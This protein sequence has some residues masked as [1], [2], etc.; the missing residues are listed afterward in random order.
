MPEETRIE[1]LILNN[2]FH[3]EDFSRKVIPYLKEEYF[4]Q[5]HEKLIFKHTTAFI[6]KYNKLPTEAAIA[7][8]VQG[9]TTM[10]EETYQEVVDALADVKEPRKVDIDWLVDQTES[11]CQEKA[12]F[13]AAKKAV[14]IMEGNDKKLEK[15]AIPQL[16]EN[17]LSVSFDPS[18]GHDYF[19]DAEKRYDV[20]HANEYKIPF[21]VDICNKVT[22]GGVTKGTL[23]VIAGGVYVGKTLALCHI[24]KS[25]MCIGKNVLDI[26][27]EISEENINNRID[28]DL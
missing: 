14:A 28:C 26:T 8:S 9:E 12:L 10:N 22:K 13:N 3:D 6:D 7:V 25:Y 16:F 1:S 11:F 5:T 15:G 21:D 18:V 19:D 2:L 20:L 23:N 4:R 27:L 17:A 24:A